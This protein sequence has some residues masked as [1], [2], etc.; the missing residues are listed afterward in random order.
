MNPQPATSLRILVADDQPLNLRIATRLLRDMGHNG[1][2]VSDGEQA[3]IA[4]EKTQFDLV[5]MDA[6]MP[7]IDGVSAV[8]E[9]RRRE[10]M[11]QGRRRT[12][13]LMVTAHDLPEDRERYRLAGAD[14]LAPKPLSRDSLQQEIQRVLHHLPR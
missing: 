4:M 10:Q 8:Q 3:L 1:V 6:T 5:L 12:P 9:I 11:Q 13:V 2:L 7:V 14:G